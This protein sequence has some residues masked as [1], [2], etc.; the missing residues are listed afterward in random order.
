METARTETTRKPT[1]SMA[2]AIGATAWQKVSSVDAIICVA[3]GPLTVEVTHHM[4]RPLQ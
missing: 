1:Y 4:D 2:G 3:T